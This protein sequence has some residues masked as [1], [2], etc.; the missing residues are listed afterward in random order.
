[1]VI[2]AAI[3]VQSMEKTIIGAE[4]LELVFGTIVLPVSASVQ[5]WVEDFSSFSQLRWILLCSILKQSFKIQS[6]I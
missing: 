1:M 3:H 6:T 2:T 4:L 5:I